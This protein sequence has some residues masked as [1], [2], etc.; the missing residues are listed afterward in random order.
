[1]DVAGTKVV[2]GEMMEVN[3]FALHVGGKLTWMGKGMAIGK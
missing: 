3:R 1:M 2:A